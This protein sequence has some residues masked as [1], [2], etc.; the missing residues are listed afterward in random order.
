MAALH[1]SLRWTVSA[2]VVVVH[3]ALHTIPAL[4]APYMT[5][6]ADIGGDD[7]WMLCSPLHIAWAGTETVYVV[8]VL[9]GLVWRRSRF[10]IAPHEV[11]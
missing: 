9:S 1:V 7:R 10:G 5:G 11:V 6:Y 3:H 8:F 4:A 2:L